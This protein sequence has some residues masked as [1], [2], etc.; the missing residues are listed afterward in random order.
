[1][2]MAMRTADGIYEL[3]GAHS[4]VQFGVRHVGVSTYRASFG[5][6]AAQLVIE[7]GSSEQEALPNGGDTLG[8]HVEITT[9]LELTRQP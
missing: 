8:R 7:N 6:I 4:T 1:M 9:H 2:T 5:D 3:D